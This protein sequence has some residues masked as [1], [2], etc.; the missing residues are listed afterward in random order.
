MV[1]NVHG[2]LILSQ[3]LSELIS[4]LIVILRSFYHCPNFTGKETEALRSSVTCIRT[5][6]W[7]V[8]EP[9]FKCRQCGSRAQ[10]PGSICCPGG[11]SLSGP[12][13][14]TKWLLRRTGQ[15]APWF[16]LDT[17]LLVAVV[18]SLYFPCLSFPSCKTRSPRILPTPSWEGHGLQE[19]GRL[20][21]EPWLL[22]PGPLSRGSPLW[23]S[24]CPFLYTEADQANSGGVHLKLKEKTYTSCWSAEG[25]Q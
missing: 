3:R 24:V 2:L 25:T 4:V 7:D 13:L 11:S 19:I 1:V 17:D 16:L 12:S 9:G 10:A 18:K 14:G 22:W 20:R 15:A 23:A 8:I 21:F 6:T 5:C